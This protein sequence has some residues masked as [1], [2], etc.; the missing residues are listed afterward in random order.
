[1]DLIDIT[2]NFM[3]IFGSMCDASF[4][5]HSS[6][7]SRLV[8]HVSDDDKPLKQILQHLTSNY[9]IRYSPNESV[10]VFDGDG[11]RIALTKQTGE[12]T[13]AITNQES[14]HEGLRIPRRAGPIGPDSNK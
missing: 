4:A 13:F 9:R 3:N 1:M 6:N 7:E 8:L 10:A 12:V 2:K 5:V 11:I 14:T